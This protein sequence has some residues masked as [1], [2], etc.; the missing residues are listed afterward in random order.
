MSIMSILGLVFAIL[1]GFGD[2]EYKFRFFP[3]K[4]KD[5]AQARQNELD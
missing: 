3:A 1:T 5:A 4:L 2:Y